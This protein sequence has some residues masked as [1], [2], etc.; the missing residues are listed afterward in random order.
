[1]TFYGVSLKGPEGATAFLSLSPGAVDLYGSR[2]DRISAAGRAQGIAGSFGRGRVVVLGEARMLTATLP[3]G[4]VGMNQPGNDDRQLALN[5][6]HWL[7]G[8]M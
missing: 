2:R 7:S 1:M 5:I 3:D 4:P 8:L 6:M